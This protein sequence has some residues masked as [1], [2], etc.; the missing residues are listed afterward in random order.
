MLCVKLEQHEGWKLG[1]TYCDKNGVLGAKV[2]K[3]GPE[4]G[5]LS[6]MWN[7][8][9][10][11]FIGWSHISIKV[12]QAK[13]FL[14]VFCFEKNLIRVFGWNHLNQSWVEIFFFFL[15]LNCGAICKNNNPFN[16]ENWLWNKVFWK[17]LFCSQ[18]LA[19]RK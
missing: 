8:R 1:K 2:S 15:A 18:F 14:F 5:F 19:L 10:F 3:M 11:L 17:D 9:M 16:Y 7:W 12:L 13:F 4:W 6:F